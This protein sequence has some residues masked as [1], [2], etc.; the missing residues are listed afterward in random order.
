MDTYIDSETSESVT[1]GSV[2]TTTTTYLRIY[3]QVNVTVQM[4]T[5]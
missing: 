2:T 3:I 4:E 1:E 5:L